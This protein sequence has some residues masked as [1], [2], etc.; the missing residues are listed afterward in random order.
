M[1]LKKYIITLKNDLAE[2]EKLQSFLEEIRHELS[3][4]KKCQFETNLALEELFSNVLFYGFKTH[5]S[6]L[7]K[8]TISASHGILNIRVMDDSEPFNPLEAMKPDL[9]YDVENCPLGGL[10][11]HLIKALMNDIQ[12][13]RHQNKN[14]LTMKKEHCFIETS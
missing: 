13:K 2:L 1:P 12:Y 7:V 10:G 9:R 14:V 8:I 5:T 3:F 4:S 6:H 11:I